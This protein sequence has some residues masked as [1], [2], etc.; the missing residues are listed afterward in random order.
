MITSQ[1]VAE[2]QSCVERPSRGHAA[3]PHASN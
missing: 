1:A 3:S 2:G